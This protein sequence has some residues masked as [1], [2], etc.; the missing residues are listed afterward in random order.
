MAAAQRLLLD[1]IP[2]LGTILNDWDL[3]NSRGYG[4]GYG[5]GYGKRAS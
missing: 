3:A 2:V 4:Y 5:Y 1:G